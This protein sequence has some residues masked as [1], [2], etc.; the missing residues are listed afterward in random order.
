MGSPLVPSFNLLSDTL[1]WDAANRKNGP[2]PWLSQVDVMMMVG[3]VNR[4]VQ[5]ALRA[6]EILPRPRS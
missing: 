5:M 6:V 2:L 4:F 1:Y 3:K